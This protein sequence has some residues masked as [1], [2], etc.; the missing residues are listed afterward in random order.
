ML[1]WIK[2]VK[3][4]TTVAVVV[5]FTVVA[6]LTLIG[7]SSDGGSKPGFVP[8]DHYVS[9]AVGETLNQ[10]HSDCTSCH[11]GLGD[12]FVMDEN[13]LLSR[14]V[15]LGAVTHDE[16]KG[17]DCNECHTIDYADSEFTVGSV[18]TNELCESCHNTDEIKAATENWNGN[19]G[20]NPHN[21]HTELACDNCH[22]QHSET[23]VLV[24]GNCHVN[25]K[26]KD[27]WSLPTN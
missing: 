6:I 14:H 2:G 19:K 15:A 13:D 16:G 23:Q 9:E 3:L 11:E 8:D 10:E 27:G 20:V 17:M 24:C 4:K 5:A 12:D 21:A 25:F 7:C 26:L 18:D 1:A 22:T